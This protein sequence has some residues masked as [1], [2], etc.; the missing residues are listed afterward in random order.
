M[1]LGADLH[2]GLQAHRSIPE[3]SA[4]DATFGPKIAVAMAL[5]AISLPP[6]TTSTNPPRLGHLVLGSRQSTRQMREN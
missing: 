5:A 6:L 3:I 4:V 1:L 2:V